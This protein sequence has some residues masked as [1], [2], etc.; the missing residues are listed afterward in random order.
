MRTLAVFLIAITCLCACSKEDSQHPPQEEPT[1]LSLQFHH[2][3]GANQLRLNSGEYVT[4]Q[5]DHVA[6][7]TLRY[8]VSNIIFFGR[9]SVFYAVPKDSCYFIVNEADESSKIIRFAVP[10]GEYTRLSFIIGVDSLKSNSD[11][12]ERTG[13]LDPLANEN[14]EMYRGPKSGYVFF[15]MEGLSPECPADSTGKTCFRFDVGGFAGHFEYAGSNIRTV[16]LRLPQGHTAVVVP[17]KP[18]TIH[19]AADLL[20][21]FDGINLKEDHTLIFSERTA[22][23]AD[24]YARMFRY[25]ES[26]K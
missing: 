22:R 14:L 17:G 4:A 2:F 9:D 1:L 12:A 18:A 26:E 16:S 13:V 15:K 20:R 6:I 8:F 19:L 3:M 21:V 23:I 11:I 5:R 25:D 24:N 10:A 7:S